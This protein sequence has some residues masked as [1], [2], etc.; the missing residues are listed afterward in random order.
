MYVFTYPLLPLGGGR[1]PSLLVVV[2]V[3]E[4]LAAARHPAAGDFLVFISVVVGA[5]VWWVGWLV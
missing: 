5:I 3:E 2:V 4:V 1:L